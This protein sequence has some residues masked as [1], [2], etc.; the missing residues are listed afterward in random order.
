MNTT[1]LASDGLLSRLS[2]KI[3]DTQRKIQLQ[4]NTMRRISRNVELLTPV[5]QRKPYTVPSDSPMLEFQ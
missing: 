5:N 1:Q 4:E 2:E 3:D